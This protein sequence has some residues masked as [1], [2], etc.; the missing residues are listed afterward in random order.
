MINNE[1]GGLYE[2]GTPF[3]S[4][5][6]KELGLAVGSD[7]KKVT[8]LLVS[9][10]DPGQIGSCIPLPEKI[11]GERAFVSLE[12]QI[13]AERKHLGKEVGRVSEAFLEEILK[14]LIFRGTGWYFE[15][16]H[17]KNFEKPFV[18]GTSR[19][20]YASRVFDQWELEH[21]V[22][23]SLEFYLTARRFDKA[24]CRDFAEYL[25]S[26]NSS[27]VK[28][29]TCNS[30]SSAN[31]LAISALGSYKLGDRRLLPGDEI[32]TV[33]ACFPTT[34]T[35]IVQNGFIPVF[36][37][38][39]L[40]SCNID[41][42][43]LEAAL[44]P[45]TR[46]IFLA[47]TLGIPFD[48][49]RVLA[50]AEKHRLWVIEDNCDALGARF[51]LSGTYEIAGGRKVGGERLTGTF[52][53]IGTS[54]FYPA[55]QMT[56]GEGGA[57]Y[58][59][60]SELYKILMSLRDWGKDCWCEPGQDNNCGKRF[61]WKL[62]GLPDQYDHKYIYSHLGYN[63]K[64]T[65]MQAAIGLAQLKKLPDFVEKRAKNWVRLRDGL[66]DLEEIFL[67]PSCLPSARPSPFGFLLTIRDSKR[68][69]RPALTGHL[70]KKG[71][72]TRTLFS[73]NILNQPA[74]SEGKP[75]FR[76]V[77]NLENTDRILHDSFWMGVYPGLTEEMI[78]FMIRTIR[79]VVSG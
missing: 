54:S 19:I 7:G 40:G 26:P 22:D 42:E 47:H 21:A 68:I 58:T 72:Q 38:V 12:N 74:F 8:F 28:V 49:E 51:S 31:L 65:D 60:D 59:A 41:V 27:A 63:L 34:V 16:V 78:D 67:I 70:E 57:V 4:T 55:H 14:Q 39:E 24:F 33:A 13:A 45:K 71:I 1:I 2:F 36:V 46:A 75:P 77:E 64:I 20:P 23:A 43:R 66:K 32:I 5:D 17:Q 50:F 61:C 3:S 29:L 79:E 52:G 11:S 69:S 73:G 10:S 18:P 9:F 44:S 76:V 25:A 35:P 48:L 37:D 53:H 30:G 56:M 6:E 15:A 62:G